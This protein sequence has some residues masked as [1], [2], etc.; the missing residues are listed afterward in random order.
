M[1]A[2][3][4]R[5][6]AR[7]SAVGSR[8]ADVSLRQISGQGSHESDYAEA[9]CSFCRGTGRNPLGILS[10]LSTCC[11]CKGRGI[12]HAQVAQESRAHSRETGAV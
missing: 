4:E 9:S 10:W 5:M 3:I 12:T 7:E 8:Y 6:T 1:V 2:G 11:V